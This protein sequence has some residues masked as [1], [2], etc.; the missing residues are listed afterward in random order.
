MDGRTNLHEIIL[1]RGDKVP[2]HQ[3]KIVLGGS[4][5]RADNGYRA[6]PQYTPVFSCAQTVKQIY[7]N[8]K[9]RRYTPSWDGAETQAALTIYLTDA[10][11]ITTA[12]CHRSLGP[13]VA[14]E[15]RGEYG[16]FRDESKHRHPR[17]NFPP[18]HFANQPNDAFESKSPAFWIDNEAM[19]SS[20]AWAHFMCPKCRHKFNPRNLR[21]IGKRLFT[22]RPDKYELPLP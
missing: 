18:Q 15:A 7:S 20:E 14:Y 4:I 9:Q 11:E 5:Y 3:P 21:K 19:K 12:C 17:G 13:F 2:R 22:D 1:P 8:A 10:I 6:I 16:V